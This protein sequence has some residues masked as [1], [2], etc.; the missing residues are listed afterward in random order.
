MMQGEDNCYCWRS[1][2]LSYKIYSNAPFILG[3]KWLGPESDH[4]PLSSAQ[5]K[6]AWSYTSTPPYMFMG[7]HLTFTQP[8]PSTFLPHK[9]LHLPSE[10]TQSLKNLLNKEYNQEL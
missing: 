1:I 7:L 6:N 3:V 10:V 2:S 4:S 8:L 5:I 9:I